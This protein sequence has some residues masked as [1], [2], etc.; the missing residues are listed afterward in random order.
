MSTT[1]DERSEATEERER[2]FRL[3]DFP[4]E[5]PTEEKGVLLSDRIKHYC[6]EYKLIDPFDDELLKPAGYELRVGRNYSVRGE[7]KALN[8]GMIL[9]I[10]PYQVAIIETYEPLTIPNFLIFRSN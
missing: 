4:L 2:L 5:R 6:K 1:S 10:G 7:R 3:P 8:D 9:E